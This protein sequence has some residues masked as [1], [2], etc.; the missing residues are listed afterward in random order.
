MTIDLTQVLIAAIGG[1]FAV[2]NAVFVVWLQGHMK[3]KAAAATLAA[4]VSNSLGAIQ[5]AATTGVTMTKPTSPCPPA[6]RRKSRSACS[7]CWI[8]PAM[9]RRGSGSRRKPSRARSTRSWGCKRLRKRHRLW[10][11]RRLWR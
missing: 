6:F 7:M 5:Q 10:W 4:A 3:D 2:I 8:M 9:K 11:L 1:A